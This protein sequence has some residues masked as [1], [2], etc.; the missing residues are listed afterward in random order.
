MTDR[1]EEGVLCDVL[2]HSLVLSRQRHDEQQGVPG[3]LAHRALP[4]DEGDEQ[5]EDEEVGG[6]LVLAG[7]EEHLQNRRVLRQDAAQLVEQQHQ[8]GLDRRGRRA[9][10]GG[11]QHHERPQD[12]LV[13]QQRLVRLPHQHLVHLQLLQLH[14]VG[15]LPAQAP[16]EEALHHV[17]HHHK[18]QDGAHGA[19]LAAL[20]LHQQEQHVLHIVLHRVGLVPGDGAEARA[21]AEVQ[22]TQGGQGGGV[23]QGVVLLQDLHHLQRTQED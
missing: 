18:L 17:L 2:G 19:G 21:A 10:A 11:Q 20:L 4:V 5:G 12:G 23:A 1:T 16:H 8:L 3:L 14:V 15:E 13:V 9:G 6:A 7:V 22:E